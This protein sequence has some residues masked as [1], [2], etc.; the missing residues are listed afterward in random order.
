VILKHYL[1]IQTDPPRQIHYRSAGDSSKQPIV[2]LHPSPV[3]SAFMQ[4]LMELFAPDCC[5]YAWDTPGYG[6]SDPLPED[7]TDLAPYVA[8]LDNFIDGL[9]LHKPLIYGSATGPKLLLNMP[10]CT[11][12]NRK[13]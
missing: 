8:A 6:Q 13:G 2:L 4:P 3:S 1:T 5:V 7:A 11:V 12:I 10:R 9:G